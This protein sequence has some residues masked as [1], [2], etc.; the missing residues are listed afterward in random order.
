MKQQAF[1]R[2]SDD[3]L[4]LIDCKI[5]SHNA[6]LALDTG[7][8]HTTIDLSVMI[9]AGY[10]IAESIKRTKIE[11][12][13]GVIEAY[14][15]QIRKLT[16]MKIVRTEIEI[17]SYD[18]FAHQVLTDIDG[19]LGLDFFKNQKLCIDFKESLITIQ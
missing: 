4:I 17:C 15:F 12:A 16:A 14:I 18:F 1:H 8:S 5:V 19:V 3:G 7:A 13:N 2:E 11:T 9:L 10:T 6:T